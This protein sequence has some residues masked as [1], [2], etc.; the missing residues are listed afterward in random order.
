MRSRG[1]REPTRPRAHPPQPDAI[2][3]LALLQDERDVRSLGLQP[4][5]DDVLERVHPPRRP[6]DLV[7]EP[8]HESSSAATSS[9]LSSTAS[10][11]SATVVDARAR[12][13]Q[14]V[15]AV[16]PRP[17]DHRL[18]DLDDRDA[19][20]AARAHAHL[21]LALRGQRRGIHRLRPGGG[22]REA[23]KPAGVRR[24]AVERVDRLQRRGA[25]AGG[26][27]ARAR[28]AAP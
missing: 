19:G 10:K 16:G 26:T 7:R 14:A 2:L 11:R 28:C 1:H 22:H 21:D 5:D 3:H 17:R 20:D 15:A 27:R 23:E 13:C 18:L 24:V 9:S 25:R 4:R 8:S 6:R 12:R